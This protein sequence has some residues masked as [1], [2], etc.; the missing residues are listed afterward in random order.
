MTARGVP[1][2]P[3]PLNAAQRARALTRLAEQPYDV[4]VVGGGVTG[5]GVALDAAS[6]GLRTALIERVDLAAGTSRWSSKLVH[7][8]LRYIGQG[9]IPIAWESAVERHHLATAIAPHL[10][11]PVATLIPLGAVVP[12]RNGLLAE[13]GTRMADVL[14]FGARTPR[15]L[16]PPPTR[17]SARDAL[18]HAPSLDPAGL[19]GGLLY[20][21]CQLEDD[22]RLVTA[23]ALTAAAY[24]ADVVTRCAASEL[25][26]RSVRLRDELT[27]E[28]FVAR[29]HVVNATGV[30]VGEHE[31]SLRVSPSRGS[32][33][34]VRTESLGNPRAVVTSPV[35]GH[36]ARFVFAIPHPDGIAHVGLT[37]EAAPGVD[38]IAPEVPAAE[39][40][41]LLETLNRVLARPLTPD[42]VVGRFAGLRPLIG[43]G[44][45]DTEDIS[46]RHLLLDRPGRPLTIAGGK[47]TTY[48]RMAQ[49]T[50]DAVLR[51]IEP[52]AGLRECHTATLPLLGAA[53]SAE[54]VRVDAPAR[55]VRRYGTLAPDVAALAELAPELAGPVA[56]GCPTLGIELLHGVLHE[57][58]LTVEDLLERRTRVSMVDTDVAAAHAA[59]RLALEVA[60]PL[61]PA[62]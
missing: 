34:V 20:W 50:V 28:S 13:V 10:V 31:P 39:A 52:H 36:L 43:D 62:S 1:V 25:T 32:H 57:G 59:A 29:G 53:S 47:L 55:L 44:H 58:A 6:R 42:D 17:L 2:R 16:L 38:G 41:F 21:D 3:V 19:R 49:D 23:I 18:L 60:A 30:W 24:G 54:L 15:A 8:G 33:L 7:G 22:A 37:D 9:N 40:T 45:S 4:I 61:S 35:P 51:R 56:P 14:R 27:G 11:R 48:R 12:A 26:D 5:A 46:R